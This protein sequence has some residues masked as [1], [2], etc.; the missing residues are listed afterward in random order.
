MAANGIRIDSFIGVTI[1]QNRP[2]KAL[3]AIKVK[4]GDVQFSFRLT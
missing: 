1:K 4:S 2:A 3:K